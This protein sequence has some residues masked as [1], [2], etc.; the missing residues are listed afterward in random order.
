MSGRGNGNCDDVRTLRPKL[1]VVEVSPRLVQHEE[2][3]QKL[4][5]Y[6][7]GTQDKDILLELCAVSEETCE[8]VQGLREDWRQH[9]EEIFKS[10]P[11]AEKIKKLQD[12]VSSMKTKL[13]NLVEVIG[14]EPP[15]PAEFARASHSDTSP[16][17][18]HKI[19]QGYGM[20]AKVA[21]LFADLGNR[22]A[23]TALTMI[24]SGGVAT[25]GVSVVELFKAY[26]RAKG[27]IP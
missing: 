20:A 10:I 8:V 1:E 4:A 23:K 15:D 16:E 19:S 13:N 24:G 26:A 25:I 22:R 27:W 2:R 6:V 11:H 18:L 7:F 14:Q 3:K 9:N 17:E 12:D 5:A 21:L